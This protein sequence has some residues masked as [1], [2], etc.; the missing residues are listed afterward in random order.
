MIDD[1]SEPETLVKALCLGILDVNHNG[2]NP[3]L[4]TDQCGAF[5]SIHE[6]MPPQLL[7]LPG[8]INR[9]PGLHDARYRV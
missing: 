7:T 4:L 1:G 6:H 2:V 8:L 9:Q 3:S 5:D